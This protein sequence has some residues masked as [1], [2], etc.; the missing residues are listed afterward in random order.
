MQFNAQAFGDAVYRDLRGFP[1]K[2]K[3][4]AQQVFRKIAQDDVCVG[5]G[6]QLATERVGGRAGY[7]A[8]R[9]GADTQG[10]R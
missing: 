6:W 9:F 1:V 4:A 5:Y 10:A 7:R 8:G 3:G 2:R